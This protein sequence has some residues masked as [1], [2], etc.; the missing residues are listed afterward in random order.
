MRYKLLQYQLMLFRH[1]ARLPNLDALRLSMLRQDDVK[2]AH[3]NFKPRRG[4]KHSWRD[5]VYDQALQAAGNLTI[6]R[7][8]ITDKKAWARI[9]SNYVGSM[10]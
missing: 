8:M 9:V 10:E 6:L 7:E 2:P 3:F 1:V 4:Q 5:R